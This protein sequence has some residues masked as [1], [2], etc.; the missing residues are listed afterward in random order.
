MPGRLADGRVLDLP[1]DWSGLA[2]LDPRQTAWQLHPPFFK[3]AI[4][5]EVDEPD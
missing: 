2:E 1:F 3:A 4:L 5:V